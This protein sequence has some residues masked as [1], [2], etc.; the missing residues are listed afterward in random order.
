MSFP[1][2]GTPNGDMTG[3]HMEADRRRVQ[4]TM[5]EAA[6]ASQDLPRTPANLVA[7]VL[8]LCVVLFVMLH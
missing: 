6:L 8:G 7:F 5:S 3:F 4:E 2:D 1:F